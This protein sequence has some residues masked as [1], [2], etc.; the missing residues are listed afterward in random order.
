MND[1]TVCCGV[2]HLYKYAKQTQ[3]VEI[4][5]TYARLYKNPRRTLKI[6]PSPAATLPVRPTVAVAIEPGATRFAVTG[7]ITAIAP[8]QAGLGIRVINPVTAAA[9]A[10]QPLILITTIIPVD[11]PRRRYHSS[12]DCADNHRL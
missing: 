3:Y 8:L 9:T 4:I 5:H 1:P 11:R 6:N 7:W 2:V 12:P 10:V